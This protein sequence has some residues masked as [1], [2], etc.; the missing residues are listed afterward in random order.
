MCA[1]SQGDDVGWKVEKTSKMGG[2]IFFSV[3][4]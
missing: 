4:P 1:A 3:H 2:S